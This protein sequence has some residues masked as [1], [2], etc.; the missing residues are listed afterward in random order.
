MQNVEF[1]A[2]LRDPIAARC[3]CELLGARNIGVLR[4]TDTYF[5]LMDGRLKR[6]EAP[7]E[8]TEWIFYHRADALG[9]RISNFSILSDEQAARRWGTIGLREWIR[10][11]KNR[12]LWMLENVRIHLDEVDNLGR[13]LE[14]EAQVVGSYSVDDCRRAVVSLR[15]TFTPCLGEPVSSGYS[16]LLAQHIANLTR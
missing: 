13:F 14:F 9:P 12:E 16:D 1:K 8:P 11:E 15:E 6:R 10:V 4:Q 7:G 5:R 2:E 3:Q